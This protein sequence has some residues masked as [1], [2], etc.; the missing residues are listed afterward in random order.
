[1]PGREE[2]LHYLTGVWL[3]VRRKPEGLGYF[4]FSDHGVARS[5][6]ALGMSL[7]FL[8]IT[9]IWA[10][11]IYLNALP[12]RPDPGF[13]LYF[14]FFMIDMITWFT[15]LLILIG[16]SIL[17][18]LE[19]FFAAT[20]VTTN[21]LAF[22]ISIF[23]ADIALLEILFPGATQVWALLWLVQ[24]TG[25]LICSYCLIA[26]VYKG[27]SLIATAVT[28]IMIIPGLLMA[29]SLQSFLGIISP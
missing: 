29:T 1:M 25:S 20:V 18:R 12:E 10:R 17:T 28:G 7:P 15:P 16:F 11:D 3:L 14:R 22:A 13:L 19:A 26:T 21:W 9:W 6:W 4:D 8:F 5:F 2:I 27:Q 24:F 23:V